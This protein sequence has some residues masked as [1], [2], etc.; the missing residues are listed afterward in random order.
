MTGA[1]NLL[2]T[3]LSMLAMSDLRDIWAIV[4]TS[5]A[6]P[7]SVFLYDRYPG[8]IGYAEKGFDRLEELLRRA[9]DIVKTCPCGR[10]CPSCVGLVNVRPPQHQDPEMYSGGYIPDK[11]ATQVILESLIS[12]AAFAKRDHGV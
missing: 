3:A 8:G 12:S 11:L 5:Q 9:L 1:K 6:P 10:G 4:N 7:V 2:M